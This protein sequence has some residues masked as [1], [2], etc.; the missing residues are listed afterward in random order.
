MGYLMVFIILEL[1]PFANNSY[2]LP[3]AALV[4]Q[5]TATPLCPTDVAIRGGT[6]AFSDG[7]HPGST[8][9]YSCPPGKYPYPLQ[10]RICQSDG[11]WTPMR[12]L[13]GI[14]ANIA[15]CKGMCTVA[16]FDVPIKFSI[17]SYASQP[18]T[19]VDIHEDI[20]EDP[21]LVLEKIQKEMNYKGSPIKLN[22]NV[23]PSTDHGNAT[24]TNIYAALNAIYLMMINDQAN[25]LEQWNKVRHAIILLTDGEEALLLLHAFK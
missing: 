21:E 3:V 25:V 4:T 17:L 8:L 5:E 13:N 6:V 16:S 24:G 12:S 2:S 1:P 15:Q 10:S 22:S 11:K 23:F 9:T 7:G 20:A 18:K 14:R 19:I